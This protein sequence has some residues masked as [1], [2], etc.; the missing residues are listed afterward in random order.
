MLKRLLFRVGLAA[1]TI[2][3]CDG[4]GNSMSLFEH[5]ETHVRPFNLRKYQLI[6]ESTVYQCIDDEDVYTDIFLLRAKSNMANQQLDR[7]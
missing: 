6:R 3:A 4:S 1:V 7:T 2:T 5:P